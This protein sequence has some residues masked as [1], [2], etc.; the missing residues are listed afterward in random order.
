MSLTEVVRA[1][2][3][4]SEFVTLVQPGVYPRQAGESRVYRASAIG[5]CPRMLVLGM[6]GY[7]RDKEHVSVV[8]RRM[9]YGTDRHAVLRERFMANVAA[10]HPDWKCMP[11]YMVESPLPLGVDDDGA[12]RI[13]GHI[14]IL[15][16][17]PSE[18]HDG[19][20]ERIVVEFKTVSAKV[21]ARMPEV[22]AG[23]VWKAYPQYRWQVAAYALLCKA[24][25]V[26]LILE[27]AQ[28]IPPENDWWS[29][30]TLRGIRW[31]VPSSDTVY[32]KRI[33]EVLG[34]YR[35]GRLPPIENELI[36]PFLGRCG[37]CP[38][39]EYCQN[40]AGEYIE[41]LDLDKVKESEGVE[42]DEAW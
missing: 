27:T 37:S 40:D 5:Y 11:E 30:G 18:V 28:S 8:Q 38:V 2:S 32:V 16:D 20:R 15:V 9:A 3:N 10:K 26:E 21:L 7:G 25:V 14:D 29:P 24:D 22:T 4:E 23:A 41:C 39:R 12:L 34:T 19:E 33:M 13:R 36:Q 1:L 35:D 6:E 42:D 17:R 31:V